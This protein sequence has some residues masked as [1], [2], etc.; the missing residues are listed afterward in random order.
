MRIRVSLYAA[1]VAAFASVACKDVINPD[2]DLC[3]PENMKVG[4]VSLRTLNFSLAVGDSTTVTASVVDPQG[5]WDLC[6][7]FPDFTSSDTTIARV[8]TTLTLPPQNIGIVT[9]VRPGKAYV[10]A[11]S[12]GVSDSVVVTVVP[13]D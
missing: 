2:I 3:P 11:T 4:K 7:L 12:G 8:R 5:N 1:V 13:R 6:L 9:G 10:K